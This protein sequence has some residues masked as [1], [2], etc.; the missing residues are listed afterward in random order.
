MSRRKITIAGAVAQRPGQ[1]GHTWVFLQYLLGLR[2]L[3]W[4]VLLLDRLEPE[5][6]VDEEGRPSTLESSVNLAYTRRALAGFECEESYALLFDAGRSVVGSTRE[7]VMAH[8]RDSEAFINVMGY[9]DDAEVLGAARHK[10]FFDIDPGF[11]HMWQDLGW[12]R[13]FDG[14]DAHVTVAGNIGREGCAIP[15]CGLEWIPTLQP[16]VLEHW[17]AQPAPDLLCFSSV[18]AWRGPYAPIEYHGRTYGLRVHE[19]RRF[20][21]LPKRTGE[22]FEIALDIHSAEERDRASLEENGWHLVDPADVAGDPWRYRAYVAASAAELMIAK[23]MYVDTH[24]GWFSDRSACYLASGRPVV[25]Q[26]TGLDGL[27][28]RDRGLLLF[29]TIEEAEDAVANVA[30]D[31]ARHAH[32]ARALAEECFDSDRVLGALLERLGLPRATTITTVGSA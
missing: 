9:V 26:D 28:P 3:G 25:A 11:S 6:C 16:I 10:V 13:L 18:G 30:S 29:S 14:Y 4:D 22:H 17:P 5:M 7:R 31:Y 24:S 12:A 23:N 19:F 15:T 32:A 27:L 2:R 1:G 8:V 20:V 21:E